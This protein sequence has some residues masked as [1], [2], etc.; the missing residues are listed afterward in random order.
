[1]T[2]RGQVQREVAYTH[3]RAQPEVHNRFERFRVST[4]CLAGP[5][6]KVTHFHYHAWPDHGVP[7]TTQ[8]LRDLVAAVQKLHALPHGPP[9]V[10]CSA[11]P[12]PL[13]PAQLTLSPSVRELLLVLPGHG[14]HGH[15]LRPPN[16]AR[17]AYGKCPGSFMRLLLSSVFI[18]GLPTRWADRHLLP[19]DI[20]L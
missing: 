11:G 20:V 2:L 17:G 5:L 10:H 12:P 1:M 13:P 4:V 3:Y 14:Q 15:N 9:V 16:I 19:L 8:P 18:F 6:R 7:S